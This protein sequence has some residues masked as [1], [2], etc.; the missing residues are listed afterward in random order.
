MKKIFVSSFNVENVNLG[1][2]EC[3]GIEELYLLD[4]DPDVNIKALYEESM[5]RA[6]VIFHDADFI[7]SGKRLADKIRRKK[8]GKL[9]SSKIVRNPNTNNLIQMWIF[10]PDWKA[11]RTYQSKIEYKDE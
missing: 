4:I 8:L 10:Y 9:Q 7:G 3:C 11:V 1:P 5:K 6:M 2:T